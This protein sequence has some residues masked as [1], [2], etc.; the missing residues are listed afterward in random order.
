M[1]DLGRDRRQV[2]DRH[3]FLATAQQARAH[4]HRVGHAFED[5]RRHV[6]RLHRAEHAG[7]DRRAGEP[8]VEEGLAHRPVEPEAEPDV[9]ARLDPSTAGQLPP[10]AGGVELGRQRG[11]NDRGRRRPV[12][13]VEA[14]GCRQAVEIEQD[15]APRH[16]AEGRRL[17]RHRV[18]V[19]APEG[20]APVDPGL[21]LAADDELV[22]AH[23]GESQDEVG[24][25]VDRFLPNRKPLG[26]AVAGDDGRVTVRASAEGLGRGQA[27]LGAQDGEPVG[28]THRPV[29]G[30]AL[31]PP[32]WIW[33]RASSSAASRSVSV[34]SGWSCL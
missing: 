28:H 13:R 31:T 10:A 32:A 11:A 14:G 4:R 2:G 6:D 30:P 18:G 7:V 1:D 24:E 23:A 22:P 34:S 9:H 5:R 12:P 26:V 33:R 16:L 17:A 21:G 20:V 25:A 27:A 29:S 8:A 15:P 19:Q 3:R